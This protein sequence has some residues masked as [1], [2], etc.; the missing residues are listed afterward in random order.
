MIYSFFPYIYKPSS[1]WDV[2]LKKKTVSR[3]PQTEWCYLPAALPVPQRCRWQYLPFH[4]KFIDVHNDI[5]VSIT[6][7][8]PFL[9]SSIYDMLYTL[10]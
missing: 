8:L 4:V 9:L 1:Q 6:Q 2:L 3:S 5:A 10:S 7:W